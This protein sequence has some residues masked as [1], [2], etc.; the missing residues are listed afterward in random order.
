MNALALAGSIS[1]PNTPLTKIPG[2]PNRAA[3][4]TWT[5]ELR[6]QLDQVHS[7]RGTGN[8]GLVWLA[9]GDADYAVLAATTV[10]V[11]DPVPVFD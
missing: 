9:T 10:A 11:G 2:K 1:F 7:A 8:N 5:K 6:H 4:M 3:Y